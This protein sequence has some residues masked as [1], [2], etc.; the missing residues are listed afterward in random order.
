M[1]LIMRYDSSGMDEYDVRIEGLGFGYTED[2]LILDGVELRIGGPQLISIIGPNGVGKSTLIYCMN[3]ILSPVEGKVYI[4]SRDVTEISIRDLSKIM[5]FV[6]HATSDVFPMT[7]MDTVLMGRH[8]K[9]GR[10][11]TEEDVRKAY[12][13]LEDLGIGELAMRPFDQ[14]SAGQHQ[15]VVLA[16][17]LA[18]EPDILLLDEPTSNLDIKHQMEVSRILKERSASLGMTVIMISHD[19]NIAAKYSAHV[20]ML[21]DGGIF[22]I[23]TPEEV[24]TENNIREVYGVESK[25]VIDEGR[26]HVIV[27]D[28]LFDPSIRSENSICTRRR[29]LLRHRTPIRFVAFFSAPY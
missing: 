29:G 11:I 15:K 19:L 4:Q 2:R 10:K 18:Q 9:S 16:R 20:I 23:G 12:A 13:I 24:I 5:G 25:V 22:R 27:R 21:Y 26:P 14:L 8:P 3:K 28:P 6:P 7:V 1:I 17:G